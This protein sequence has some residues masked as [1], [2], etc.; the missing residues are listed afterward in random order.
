MLPRIS[1]GLCTSL[2]DTMFR[3]PMDAFQ[4]GPRCLK[5]APTTGMPPI[6]WYLDG[7]RTHENISHILMDCPH[8]SPCI[9]AHQ[10]LISSCAP[11]QGQREAA[12]MSRQAFI[13][14]FAYRICHG[15]ID[16]EPPNSAA[17]PRWSSPS[18][19]PSSNAFS[20]AATAT[21][22]PFQVPHQTPRDPN[23]S[24]ST[25]CS[26][27]SPLPPPP[28]TPGPRA[29][30]NNSASTSQATHQRPCPSRSGQQ[31]GSKVALSAGT[32]KGAALP[33]TSACHSLFW[34]HSRHTHHLTLR[35]HT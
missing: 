1:L 12:G 16:F 11:P 9:A 32:T 17:H 27:D 25:A 14:T 10:L 31:H 5:P 19:A 6:C 26:P 23:P 33:S 4:F 35:P 28:P 20:N 30:M 3:V 2:K 13:T 34:L 22:T 29:L 8:A 18:P 21:P 7:T 24:S 15:C